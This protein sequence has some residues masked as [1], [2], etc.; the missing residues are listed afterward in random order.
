[1][2]PA[3]E[4]LLERACGE[5]GPY[6]RWRSGGSSGCVR[7]GVDPESLLALAPPPGGV[8]L[9]D[10]PKTRVFISGRWF[11]K[12]ILHRGVWRSFRHTFRPPR[13]LV[14]LAGA[15]RLAELGV[16]TPLVALAVR[17]RRLGLL[18]FRDVLVTEA[19]GEGRIF[20]DE[21]VVGAM[22]AGVVSRLI[23][24]GAALLARMHAG[25]FEQGDLNLRNIYVWP[26]ANGEFVEMGVIDLDGC[27]IGEGALPTARRRREG[28]RFVSSI[29]KCLRSRRPEFRLKASDLVG[30][31]CLC[32]RECCGI[33]LA[34]EAMNKR[35]SYLISRKRRK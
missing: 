13:P 2:E 23:K 8:L 14:A 17:R 11:C 28:A 16:P 1:M 4:T 34:G 24:Q 29:I 33:D 22:S 7:R 20:A 26:G 6:R 35:V 9:K 32:Y 30:E 12:I 15:L 27:R 25:G 19:L 31:F 3:Y 10:R 5:N 21:L 18:P